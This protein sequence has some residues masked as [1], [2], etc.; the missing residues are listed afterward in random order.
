VWAGHAGV[1]FAL[2]RELSLLRKGNEGTV[3]LAFPN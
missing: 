2:M 3:G 1:V